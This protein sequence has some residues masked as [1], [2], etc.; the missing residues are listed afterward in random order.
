MALKKLGGVSQARVMELSQYCLDENAVLL[1]SPTMAHYYDAEGEPCDENYVKLSPTS[2]R[3][4]RMAAMVVVPK[5]LQ[6]DIC[7]LNHY[8]KHAGHPQWGDMVARIRAAGY[9]WSG[10]KASCKRMCDQCKVCFQAT[11]AR[12]HQRGLFTSRRYRRP[13]EAISWDFQVL[14][15]ASENNPVSYTHLTLPTILRV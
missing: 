11:R 14:G 5:E 12:S 7:Y 4:D 2:V 6:H 13:F 9:T 15:V 1:H 8:S 10:I 3:E